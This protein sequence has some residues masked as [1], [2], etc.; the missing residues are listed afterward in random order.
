M[1]EM[2]TAHPNFQL[3]LEVLA[4]FATVKP[5]TV[6]LDLL[7]RDFGKK[8]QAELRGVMDS[9]FTKFLIPIKVRRFEGRMEAYLRADDRQKAVNLT[10][11]YWESVYGDEEP[12]P[13]G[14]HR[15]NASTVG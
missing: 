2:D 15:W 14:R 4:C 8:T 7:C 5:L 12:R 13:I 9:I 11:L 6:P 3:E 10:T 1:I